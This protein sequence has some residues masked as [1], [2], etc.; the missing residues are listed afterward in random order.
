MQLDSC[1]Q[2]EQ[3]VCHPTTGAKHFLSRRQTWDE[4][5]MPTVLITGCDEGLG[6]GFAEAYAGDGWDVIA[7]YR[8]IANRWGE[9]GIIRHLALDVTRSS[10][11]VALKEKIGAAPIDVLISNAAIAI[12][13]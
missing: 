7:T 2:V 5:E 8:D 12:D 1:T 9:D 13:P 6:R 11:F 4:T 3:G 10:D